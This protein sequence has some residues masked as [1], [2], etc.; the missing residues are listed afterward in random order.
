MAFFKNARLLIAGTYILTLFIVLVLDAKAESSRGK[1]GFFIVIE[2]FFVV[3]FSLISSIIFFSKPNKNF[4]KKE[5]TIFIFFFFFQMINFFLAHYLFLFQCF[6]E[7]SSCLT[8][9][10]FSLLISSF[11]YY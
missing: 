7:I 9:L 5:Y 6:F 4:L 2:N 11:F 3:V 10:R 8:P 1:I